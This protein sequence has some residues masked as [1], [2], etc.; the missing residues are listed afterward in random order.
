VTAN[1]AERRKKAERIGR[2]AETRAAVM[3]RL[4]GYEILSR[5]YRTPAGELDL[6][7][8]RAKTVA[9][10]EVK[11]RS[12]LEEA[13]L[14]VTPVQRRRIVNAARHWLASHCECADHDC[15]FDIVLVRPYQW[16]RHYANAFAAD[17]Q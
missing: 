13:L 2:Q 12:C 11:A 15:R 5:R 6:V 16:P 8:R 17:D 4:K 10:V 14:A 7:V 3:F 9:F 1:E